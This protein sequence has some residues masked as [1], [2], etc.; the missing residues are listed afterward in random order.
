MTK[1]ATETMTK[2]LQQY[3]DDQP[4]SYYS[5]VTETVA[6]IMDIPC[7]DHGGGDTKLSEVYLDFHDTANSWDIKDNLGASGCDLSAIRLDGVFVAICYGDHY[8]LFKDQASY[9]ATRDYLH[10]I[11]VGEPYEP[12]FCE[13]LD[14]TMGELCVAAE[15]D[16]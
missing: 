14:K 6:K 4:K 15:D 11:N 16:E 2:T 9:E 10:S 13:Y 8:L 3:I 1:P 5:W 7:F 12:D